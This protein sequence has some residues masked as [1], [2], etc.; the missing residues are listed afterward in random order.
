MFNVNCK[1]I[2]GFYVPDLLKKS[3]PSRI[4]IVA[5]LAHKWSALDINNLNGEK[6]K[7][8]VIIYADSKLCNI[9][10]ANELAV[11]LQGTSK[12]ICLLF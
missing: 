2:P 6:Y 7:N 10:F 9:L 8:D 4:V 12:N 5:S 3:S 1:S 11:R